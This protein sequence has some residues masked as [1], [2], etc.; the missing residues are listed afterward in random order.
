MRRERQ[1]AERAHGSGSS[2]GHPWLEE[3]IRSDAA[4]SEVIASKGTMKKFSDR[5]CIFIPERLSKAIR[6]PLSTRARTPVFLGIFES[7]AEGISSSTI[8]HDSFVSY[9]P[10]EHG[11]V[12]K[13]TSNAGSVLILTIIPSHRALHAKAKRCGIF[14]PFGETSRFANWANQQCSLLVLLQREQ[15]ISESFWK[16]AMAQKRRRKGQQ[17]SEEPRCSQKS[18]VRRIHAGQQHE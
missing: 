17:K 4:Y 2:A 3:G 16:K 7:F 18:G 1:P 10:L 8:L 9:Y 15:Q 6:R 5:Q 13:Y 11:S 12:R 14:D